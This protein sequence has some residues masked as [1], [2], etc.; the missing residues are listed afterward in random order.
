MNTTWWGLLHVCRDFKSPTPWNTVC[1]A[2]ICFVE[3]DQY[4]E[5]AL[6]SFG[7]QAFELPPMY[8]KTMTPILS[9]NKMT[10]VN[11]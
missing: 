7:K 3:R 8:L 6:L 10:F 1:Q 11:N 4:Q 2:F 5:S 9:N